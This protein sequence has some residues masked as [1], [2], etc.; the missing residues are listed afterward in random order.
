MA[1]SASGPRLAEATETPELSLFDLVQAIRRRGRLV[2]GV[3]LG[4]TALVA[5]V[6][7]LWPRSYVGSASFYPQKPQGSLAPLAGLA[8]QFGVALPGAQTADSPEFYAS[9]LTS[10]E[11]L[12]PVVDSTYDVIG[13]DGRRQTTL[14]EVFH[15]TASD[16]AV[17]RNR[18]IRQLRKHMD[19]R[20][21]FETGVVQ[22]EVRA[23]DRRIALQ[24][25]QRIVAEMSAF[26]LARRRQRAASER[27]FLEER[28]QQLAEELRAA[29]RR[30]ESFLEKNREYRNAP[31]LTFE[32]TRRAREV[33]MR[34]AVYTSF[35]Q[36]YEQARVDEVRNTPV[37]TLV[38]RPVLP[39]EPAP[40]QLLLKVALALSLSL[41]IAVAAAL[42]HEVLHRR[43]AEGHVSESERPRA[44]A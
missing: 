20:V 38:E 40:R 10:R 30:H 15:V 42:T 24:V 18:T 1:P 22:L 12:G 28:L 25:V 6:T 34:Q 3:P 36:A 8:A 37:L 2:L 5:V 43:A 4:L 11:I 27:V 23:G 7:L 13:R 17:R 33:D 41:F 14:A 31:D 26:N 44:S 39:A 19:A 21:E 32:N 35:A 9:L 16:S 29:E